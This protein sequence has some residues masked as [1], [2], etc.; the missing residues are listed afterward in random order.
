MSQIAVLSSGSAV[1]PV[2][3]AITTVGA[4]NGNVITVPLG[5]IPGTYAI[6][7]R[8]A[9]FNASTPAGAG[10]EIFGAVR[11][12][13]AAA[14]LVGSPDVIAN[15]EAALAAADADLI[16]SGNNAIIQV[17]G[18]AGLTI[19]WAATLFFTRVT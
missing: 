11:T 18:V 7:A 8:V 4:V 2:N 19:D 5:S 1:G 16:V 10:Y 9:S 6:E 3:G 12:T 13:G 14:V 15:E 17:T